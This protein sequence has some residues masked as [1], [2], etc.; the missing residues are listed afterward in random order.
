LAAT[1]VAA[2]DCKSRADDEY[3]WTGVVVAAPT[4][5]PIFAP[6]INTILVSVP[7]L[8]EMFCGLSD[9]HRN[10]VPYYYYHCYA[11]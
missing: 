9:C 1:A 3:F 7:A 2:A 10:D 8:L 11:M 5:G 4:L 6:Q